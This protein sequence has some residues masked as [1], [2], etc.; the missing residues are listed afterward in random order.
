VF[1]DS[2][3][4]SRLLL[5][6]LAFLPVSVLLVTVV[7]NQLLVRREKNALLK[8]LNMVIGACFTELGTTLLTYFSRLDRATERIAPSLL[9]GSGWSENEFADI[10]ARVTKL[11]HEIQCEGRTLEELKKVLLDNRDFFLRLLEN[12]V[13]LEHQAFTDLLW[14][15]TH[16]TEELAHREDLYG[17]SVND[18]AHLAGDIERAY[19][20]L[21]VRWIAY[22]EHL[23]VEYPY[24]FSLAL[25]TNP[26]DTDAR[27][28]VS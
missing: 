26:F 24:L 6:Q 8:K 16:L 19:R 14:A 7:L 15:V 21:L 27:P 1:K 23:K 10:A 20:A 12:P 5:A 18:A 11:E 25:R 9:M 28:E 22:M 13:L 4:L 2:F 17:L 3:F